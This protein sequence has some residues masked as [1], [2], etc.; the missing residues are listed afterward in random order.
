MLIYFGAPQEV[1]FT[2]ISY[3]LSI[4]LVKLS[5]L[6][7]Y[8]RVF[9]P[10]YI[11]KTTYAVFAAVALVSLWSVLSSIFFCVPVARYWDPTVNGSCLPLQP[12]WISG[13]TLNIASDFVIFVLPLTVVGRLGLPKR[14]KIG[15]FLVFA[16]GFL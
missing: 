5:I 13:A 10:V 4:A 3:N 12:R 14:Q 1:Y 11:R 7:L 2:I 6:L 9:T 16:L 8:L 15:L